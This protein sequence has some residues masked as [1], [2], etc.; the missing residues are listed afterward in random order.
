M[1]FELTYFTS[2]LAWRAFYMGTLSQDEKTMRLE[3]YVRIGNNSGE[4]YENAQT[5][6]LVGR[7]HLLDEIARLA[8]RPQ[9][10]YG[11]PGLSDDERRTGFRA[12]EEVGRGMRGNTPGRPGPMELMMQMAH[13][14]TKGSS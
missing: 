10:P 9:Y 5:R 1:P 14:K 4:D 12:E 8:K 11:M 6:L 13:R 2:G 3:G 7:V